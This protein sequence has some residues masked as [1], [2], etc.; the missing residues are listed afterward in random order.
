MD[1]SGR[2]V[3]MFGE[4]GIKHGPTAIHIVDKYVYVCEGIHI[5]VYET[6]GWFVTSFTIGYDE[7]SRN[8]SSCADGFIYV[9]C[10]TMATKIF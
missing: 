9:S 4:E 1:R 8:I 6:S 5:L 2:F 7:W 10:L 3:Q